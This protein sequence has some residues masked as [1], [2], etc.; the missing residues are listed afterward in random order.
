[1]AEYNNGSTAKKNEKRSVDFGESGLLHILSLSGAAAA[2][3]KP[4]LEAPVGLVAGAPRPSPGEAGRLGWRA[5]GALKL[6]RAGK[7]CP[8]AGPDL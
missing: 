2:A 6:E 8:A 1:V 3:R 5:A 4:P 7:G